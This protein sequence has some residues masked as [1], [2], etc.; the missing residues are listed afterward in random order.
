MKTADH[1]EKHGGC[2]T[3]PKVLREKERGGRPE[4]WGGIQPC[5]KKAKRARKNTY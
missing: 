4:S 2:H 3:P 5:L 1:I